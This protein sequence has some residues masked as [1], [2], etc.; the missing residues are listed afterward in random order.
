MHTPSLFKTPHAK[1]P[2]INRSLLI[3]YLTPLITFPCKRTTELRQTVTVTVAAGKSNEMINKRL[4]VISKTIGH[5][6]N[7]R[8]ATPH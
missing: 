4:T 1:I 3:L 5:L 6:G 7:L 8:L 2:F